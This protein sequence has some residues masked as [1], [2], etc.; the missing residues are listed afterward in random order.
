MGLIHRC[1]WFLENFVFK[2]MLFF[3]KTLG[4]LTV[5]L[6]NPKLQQ[7]SKSVIFEI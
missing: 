5:K 1:E 6:P 3:K 4:Y 2:T 7:E